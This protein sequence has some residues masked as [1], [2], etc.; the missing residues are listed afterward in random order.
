MTKVNHSLAYKSRAAYCTAR[1]MFRASMM[2]SKLLPAMTLV[3]QLGG[4]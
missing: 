3:V 4:L 1:F 2:R